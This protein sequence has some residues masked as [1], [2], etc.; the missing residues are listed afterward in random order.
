[1]GALVDPSEEPLR[2]ACPEEPVRDERVSRRERL[3]LV[4]V[5]LDDAA[6]MLA[7]RRQDRWHPAYPRP[8]DVDAATLVGAEAPA[9]PRA[10]WGPRHIVLD[11]LAVGSIGFFGPPEEGEVE[12]GFGLVAP[13]R[14][15]G[16][17]SEAL[18]A[19]LARADRVGVRVR[20]ATEPDN[21]AS[22]RV[23]AKAGFTEVRG[24]DEDGRLVLARPVQPT[25]PAH[26]RSGEMSP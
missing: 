8:D 10:S 26:P 16:L 23:L 20:A 2:T 5:S 14:G 3:R 17:A 1:M 21:G 9:S 4:L 6:D 11:R 13:V 15:Q 25:G 18:G 7:G 24:G 12:V 22:L 19:L